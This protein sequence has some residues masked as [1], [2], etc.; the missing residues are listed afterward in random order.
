MLVVPFVHWHTT[1]PPKQADPAVRQ[2]SAE[3][4][5]ELLW[6]LLLRG[7]DTFF[8]WCPRDEAPEEVR[9]VHEVYSDAQEYGQFLEKGIPVSFE[10]PKEPGPVVSALQLG[11]K[12]LVRRTDFTNS[13][14]PAV[15]VIEGKKLAVN[16]A[17]GK[18][19]VMT[20]K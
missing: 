12:L 15:L 8:L 10:V 14:Q 5:R 3:S 6:H 16:R 1:S 18:C 4:Y 11:D 9:L 2:F 13:Q 17:P 7:A 19:T 20:L